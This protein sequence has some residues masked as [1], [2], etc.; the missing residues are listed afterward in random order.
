MPRTAAT[1]SAAPWMFVEIQ[2]QPFALANTMSHYFKDCH[3][4]DCR[5]ETGSILD[6]NAI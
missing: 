4:I 3:F 2:E 5:V 6:T 1:S